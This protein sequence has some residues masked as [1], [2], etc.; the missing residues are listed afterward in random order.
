M[1]RKLIIALTMPLVGIV[2]FVAVVPAQARDGHA[3]TSGPS[4]GS[5]TISTAMSHVVSTMTHGVAGGRA[6][7]GHVSRPGGARPLAHHPFD[8]HRFAHHG[9]VSFGVTTVYAP[10]VWDGPSASDDPAPVYAPP[11]VYDAPA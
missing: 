8:D 4:I 9:F 7:M 6:A 10:P 11:V 3:A 1:I 2:S 5:P